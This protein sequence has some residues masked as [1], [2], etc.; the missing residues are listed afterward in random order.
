MR[1]RHLHGVDF[2]VADSLGLAWVQ[3]EMLLVLL[4]FL[5]VDLSHHKGFIATRWRDPLHFSLGFQREILLGDVHN[6]F[7]RPYNLTLKE[8][9]TLSWP[10]KGN[11]SIVVQ[12]VLGID[13]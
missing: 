6:H 12:E 8:R 11:I 4:A 5:Q 1:V 2:E 3:T 9:F 7:V 13:S 10:P